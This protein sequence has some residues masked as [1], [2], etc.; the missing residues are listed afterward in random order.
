MS[1]GA[2]HTLEFPRH[3]FRGG[4]G[5]GRRPFEELLSRDCVRVCSC[6]YVAGHERKAI[7]KLK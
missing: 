7:D 1:P 3:V 5:Y 6:K 4:L 2:A